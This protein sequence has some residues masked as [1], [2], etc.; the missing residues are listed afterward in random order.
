MKA[1][2]TYVMSITQYQ[3]K[4]EVNHASLLCIIDE[5]MNRYV[6]THHVHFGSHL[7]YFFLNCF[8]WIGPK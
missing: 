1:I 8:H 6:I 7:A 5:A 4:S 2:K 3:P